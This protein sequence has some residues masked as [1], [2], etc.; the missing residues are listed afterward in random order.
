[1]I[2]APFYIWLRDFMELIKARTGVALKLHELTEKIV[3]ECGY[4]LYDDEYITG[5][6]T[7]R[8]FIMNDETK[9][10][11]IEDCIKVDRSF[12][13]YCEELD[14]I[15]NDFVLEV[16]SPGV[17]R[18]L[19]T[20][21]HFELAIGEFIEFSISG[22]LDLPDGAKFSKSVMKAKKLRGFLKEVMSEKI[23]IEVEKIEIEIAFSQMKKANLDPDLR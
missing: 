18:S 11:V 12:S 7:L 15:P 9:T 13:P 2:S 8:V 5:S 3:S 22:S 16:S 17:Y 19:K 10:A 1:M 23:K 21:K 20:H 6:S 14:W 4:T